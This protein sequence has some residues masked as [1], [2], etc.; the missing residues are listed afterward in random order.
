M[1]QKHL[2]HQIKDSHFKAR[3]RDD[4]RFATGASSEGKRKEMAKTMTKTT[5]REVIAYVGSQKAN[6]Q[7]VICAHSRK[8]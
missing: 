2:E 3:N 6:V 1:V 7:L 4:D 5:Q 8:T